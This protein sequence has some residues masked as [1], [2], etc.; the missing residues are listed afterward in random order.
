MYRHYELNNLYD[1]LAPWVF[2][3]FMFV[4]ITGIELDSRAIIWG[5][6]FIAIKGNQ[7]DGRLYI[8]H[9]I[10]RGAVAILSESVNHQT[11]MFEKS[12][13]D[14]NNIPIIYIKHLNRYL[15]SIAARF[16]SYPS[17]FLDL[18]GV[19][20]TN[21]KT[22]VTCLLANWTQL[23]GK[24]SAVMGTLGNGVLDN[25]IYSSH[26]TTSSAV[27]N[28]KI[29][30]KFV[31]HKIT[32]VAMEV[33]SHGLDQYRVD[34]LC[35][36]SAVFTN[37]S[38]DHLDYHGNIKKYI[39]AKW[40]LFNELNVENY[41]INADDFIGYQWLSC[42]PQA[43]A[44]TTGAVPCCWKGR[45]VR[46]IN[47]KYHFYGTNIIFDSSWGKGVIY[48]PLLGEF[49]VNNLLLA[50][51]T[52]LVLGYSLSSLLHTASQLRSVCGRM[53][54]FRSFSK[55]FP[56][57]MIDYAHTPDAL[58]KVLIWIKQY[59][60]GKL[61]C[62]FGCGGDR[63][64]GKRSLMGVIAARYS[65]YVII[66]N[67]NPRTE[68]PQIIIDNIMHDIKYMKKVKVIQDRSYAIHAVIA[69]ALVEDI[70]LIAGKGHE[71]YQIIG[72]NYLYYSDRDVVKNILKSYK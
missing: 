65:D 68:D 24:K 60:L 28:Q 18:I 8:N 62:I 19:T 16:Y 33:S 72:K 53:E 64:S 51:A 70:I 1:L 6:L 57:V 4:Y 48:S 26:N 9:A 32:F 49:N 61:W 15:S 40:R 43:V 22:T 46:V 50:L 67:D 54:I 38:R 2:C 31:Q 14:V 21:G 69:R 37:L 27:D 55:K 71:T 29:L 35:F 41:V 23:L 66:T 25:I 7:T 3:R 59:C 5:N 13:C 47:L 63:D 39:M 58:K 42:L 20:G 45:W 52:L 36:K 44:V 17:Y 12:N 56:T 11:T 10:K 34:A 30:A